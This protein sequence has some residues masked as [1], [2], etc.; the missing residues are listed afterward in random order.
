MK[1]VQLSTPCIMSLNV[2]ELK[3]KQFKA[4]VQK[5]HQINLNCEICDP[6]NPGNFR[7]SL[8]LI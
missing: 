2:F 1:P 8:E 5:Q 7:S 4:L 6:V 3:S